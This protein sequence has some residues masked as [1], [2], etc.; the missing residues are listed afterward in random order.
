MKNKIRLLILLVSL[1][2][3]FSCKKDSQQQIQQQSQLPSLETGLISFNIQGQL[4]PTAI[5]TDKNIISVVV[6]HTINLQN[7]TVNFSLANQVNASIKNTAINSGSV[8][9]LSKISYLTVTSADK[10]RSTTYQ[11]NIET[12]LYYYGLRGNLISENSLNKNYNFYYDQFDGSEWASINCGPTVS[13]MA[14]KWAD[15]TFTKTPVDARAMYNP[16]GGWWSTR[17][18]ND[19]VSHSG[20]DVEQ[21]TLSNL[22]SLVKVN[23]DKNH[24]LILCLDMYYVSYNNLASAHVNKFYITS[25]PAWGHFLLVKGYKQTTSTFYLEVYDP[26]SNGMEYYPSIIPHELRGQDRYYTSTD[27]K[28]ATDL[29]NPYAFVIAPKGLLVSG[30]PKLGT[31]RIKKPI[32]IALG[33]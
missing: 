32:A 16:Q 2:V 13:T 5:D 8:I 9:D 31:S 24:T 20:I 27:I 15:S 3:V 25:A 14:I 30:S 33:R 1:S 4:F 26:Y 17:N 29:W 21:D 10:K 22:D 18:V 19:Y 6:P 12:D 23:I 7:L 11:L 28:T